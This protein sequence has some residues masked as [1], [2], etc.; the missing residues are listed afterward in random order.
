MNRLQILQLVFQSP[1]SR[2]NHPSPRTRTHFVLPA[3]TDL[4]FYGTVEYSEDFLA[5]I[6]TPILNKF[7]MSFFL[8][9]SLDAFGVSH[10]KQFIGRANGLK[11]PKVARVY[12]DP[13]FADLDLSQQG[14]ILETTCRRIDW[15]V[16]SIALVCGRP[17]AFCSSIERLDLY[18]IRLPFEVEEEDMMYTELGELFRRFTGIQT[19]RVG[20]SFLPFV[21]TALLDLTEEEES[22]TLPNLRDIFYVA[23]KIPEDT[24]DVMRNFLIARRRSGRP[25]GAHQCSSLQFGTWI[26]M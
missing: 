17:P 18:A 9:P 2:P 26:D 11:P 6:D 21:A 25:V 20:R 3:L 1:R 14:E 8:D 23:Y 22:A 24:Q 19:L 7:T 16:D 15:Q 5:R 10:F 4:I 12:F 13:S